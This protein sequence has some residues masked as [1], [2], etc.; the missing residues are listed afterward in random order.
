MATKYMP[1]I[2]TVYENDILYEILITY[3]INLDIKIKF[4]KYYF[5]LHIF[6]NTLY[7]I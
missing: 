1:K 4:K 5:I 7:L 2:K 3:E 6:I